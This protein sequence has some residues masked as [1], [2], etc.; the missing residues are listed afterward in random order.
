VIPTFIDEELDYI[1]ANEYI[2]IE[3]LKRCPFQDCRE[4]P[5]CVRCR[6]IWDNYANKVEDK[7]LK[8]SEIIKYINRKFD[9]IQMELRR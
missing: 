4:C 9:N 7:K 3:W 5:I 8:K 6:R 1:E 2:A